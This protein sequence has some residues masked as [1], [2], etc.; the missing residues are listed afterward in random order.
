[1]LDCL[2][3]ILFSFLPLPLDLLAY[4]LFRSDKCGSK[5]VKEDCKGVIA[6]GIQSFHIRFLR[7]VEL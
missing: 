5:L 3:G 2:Q 4:C 6:T 7:N 1:M